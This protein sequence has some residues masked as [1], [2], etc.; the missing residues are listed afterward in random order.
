MAW[1]DR[2]PSVK[3]F[4]AFFYV[5]THWSTIS[6]DFEEYRRQIKDREEWAL[7]MLQYREE[8]HRL[9]Q[10]RLQRDLSER[11]ERAE[12]EHA[13]VKQYRVEL[14]RTKSLLNWL[15]RSYLDVVGV[16]AKILSQEEPSSR[17]L[18][19]SVLGLE[20]QQLVK[21]A[22]ASLPPPAQLN[23]RDIARFRDEVRA[24][25]VRS[26]TLS[27]EIRERADIVKREQS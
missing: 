11:T 7:T 15:I 24:E 23:L 25:L 2:L 22:I 18:L 12:S 14:K 26:E 4:A 6:R 5:A 8:I 13:L 17:Q 9:E 1:T 27:V 10:E 16:L 3:G 21:A 19:L 20:T